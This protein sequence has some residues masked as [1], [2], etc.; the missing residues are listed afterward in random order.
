MN[1][2]EYGVEDTRK[3]KLAVFFWLMVLSAIEAT[4]RG[5]L[6]KQVTIFCATFPLIP[7]VR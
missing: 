1:A 6:S 5:C 3:R 2:K 7:V 4:P